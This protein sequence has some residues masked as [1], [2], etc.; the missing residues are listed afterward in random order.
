MSGLCSYFSNVVLT[1]ICGTPMARHHFTLSRGFDMSTSCDYSCKHGAYV[2][3]Q[4]NLTDHPTPLHLA[5]YKGELE[6][7]RLLLQW[8]A[9]VDV[10]INGQTPL[11]HA[12]LGGY[13][14]IM[15]L[16]LDHG[17]DVM[18]RDNEHSTALHLAAFE[19]R[20]CATRLLLEHG[21]KV[22]VQKN[23]GET[24]FQV[25]SARG[26]SG[27]AQMLV[28]HVHTTIRDCTVVE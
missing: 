9:D 4:D 1:S 11:H 6:A 7:A 3:T 14:E 16:L 26:H 5:S 23:K 28:D 2:G 15:K 10:Q 22:H 25:A 18:A 21:S 8:G 12:S 20:V 17:A 19:G 13:C 24:P 27:V